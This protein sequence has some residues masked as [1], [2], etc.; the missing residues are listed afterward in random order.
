M[1]TMDSYILDRLKQYSYNYS[2][3]TDTNIYNWKFYDNDDNLIHL[4]YKQD[5]I[6][7]KFDENKITN[8][9]YKKNKKIYNV[10]GDEVD[11]YINKYKQYLEK[12]TNNIN[13]NNVFFLQL[14]KYIGNYYYF[15]NNNYIWEISRNNFYL[16]IEVDYLKDAE[17]N[18]IKLKYNNNDIQLFNINSL[19]SFLESL[20]LTNLN[21]DN[22]NKKQ[23]ITKMKTGE[24]KQNYNYNYILKNPYIPNKQISNKFTKLFIKNKKETRLYIQS[25]IKPK[26]QYDYLLE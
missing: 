13:K 9:Y 3:N 22:D 20:N 8:L 5:N 25:C 18:I 24:S 7:K 15:I 17:S 21:G 11:F 14:Y 4:I 19:L 10:F 6:N 12:V 26:E 2:Y 16:Y 23:E 1:F